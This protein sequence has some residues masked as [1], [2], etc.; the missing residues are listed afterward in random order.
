[1]KNIVILYLL[2]VSCAVTAQEAINVSVK[3][4]SMAE[5]VEW[6]VE[7]SIRVKTRESLLDDA[8]VGYAESLMKHMPHI[9]AGVAA[10]ST[11]GR[12]IDPATDAYVNATTLANTLNVTANVMLFDGLRMINNTRMARIARL[13][14][15]TEL[16]E[17]KDK[18]AMDV[19]GLYVEVVYAKDMEI[20]M[21]RNLERY[22]MEFKKMERMVELGNGSAADAAQMRARISKERLALIK[23]KN[24]RYAALERLKIVMGYDEEVELRIS[25][26]EL[27]SI[28]SSEFDI[29]RVIEFAID[30]NVGMMVKEQ[31]LA[32]AKRQLGIAKGG[33]SPSIG[34]YGGV[35]TAFFMNVGQDMYI[36]YWKQLEGNLGEWVGVSIKI[37]IFGGGR[38]YSDLRRAKNA[39]QRAEWEKEDKMRELVAEVRMAVGDLEAAKESCEEGRLNVEYQR[40]ANDAVRKKFEAG[41]GSIV[42]VHISDGELFSAEM[43]LRDAELRYFILQK[44]VGYYCGVALY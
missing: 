18:V 33:F 11:F 38:R 29:E 13:K 12:G 31:G 37:P 36:P 32:I 39:L 22:E 7:N 16:E 14:G 28:G 8:R 26:V 41:V 34:L 30:K 23:A 20:L 19:M 43:A 3:K 2:F 40:L 21:E 27:D 44:Q 6:A 10:E 17:E 35:S 1:M 25:N 24:A 42:D 4:L 9:E 5:C 15:K